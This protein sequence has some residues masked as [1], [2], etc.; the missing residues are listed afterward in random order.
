MP[1][2]AAAQTQKEKKPKARV[3]PVTREYTINLAKQTF[4]V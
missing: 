1:K 4:G 3:R 2:E